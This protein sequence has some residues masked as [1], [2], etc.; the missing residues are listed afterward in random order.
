MVEP[1]FVKKT[2]TGEFLEIAYFRKAV[3]MH[4]C[5]ECKRIIPE[6]ERYVE[7]RLN[8][9]RHYRDYRS[10]KVWHIHKVCQDC[11]RAPVGKGVE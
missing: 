6:G 4:T 1:I 5:G 2:P 8:R 10:F 11:W 9:V 3:K 7:D